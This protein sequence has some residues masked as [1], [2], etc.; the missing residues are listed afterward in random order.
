MNKLS[1]VT[2]TELHERDAFNTE[3]D[4]DRVLNRLFSTDLSKPEG[5]FCEGWTTLDC[6]EE[7]LI[8]PKTGLSKKGN[9]VFLLA[10]KYTVE[11]YM[12]EHV[13][14][15]SYEGRGF[16]KQTAR[17]KFIDMLIEELNYQLQ[18]EEELKE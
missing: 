6:I 11:N 10:C 1:L 8:D 12:I 16:L 15:T 14:N 18:T 7:Y 3:D 4:K 2:I 13:P 5:N 17:Y 9:G